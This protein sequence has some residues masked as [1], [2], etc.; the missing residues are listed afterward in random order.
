MALFVAG[1]A[2]NAASASAGA[3]RSSQLKS[4]SIAAVARGPAAIRDA[5]LS[6][7]QIARL[8]TV[9]SAWGGPYTTSSGETVTVYASTSYPMDSALGQRWADFLAG[10]VHGSELALITVYLAPLNEVQTI[11]GS[12]AIGCYSP[13]DNLR[14]HATCDDASTARKYRHTVLELTPTRLQLPPFRSLAA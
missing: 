7:S 14:H 4:P 10:L 2:F 8:Q 3:T 12:Q 11:C 5:V 1:F 6:R 13:D 9:G